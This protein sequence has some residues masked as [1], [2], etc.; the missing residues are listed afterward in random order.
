MKTSQLL[1]ETNPT[2]PLSTI[3]WTKGNQTLTED[4]T[5]TSRT[6]DNAVVAVSMATFTASCDDHL[7]QI[8]CSGFYKSTRIASKS[9][10]LF[11]HCI[12]KEDISGLTFSVGVGV[13]VGMAICL[14]PLLVAATVCIVWWKR[15]HTTTEKP[16]A[17]ESTENTAPA[18]CVL[19]ESMDESTRERKETTY[20]EFDMQVYE[21]PVEPNS[22]PQDDA[23]YEDV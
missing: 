12:D 19:Y 23:V 17:P 6:N 4:V 9:Q 14:V 15:R 5:S 8:Q 18:Q 1:C 20:E 10:T 3:I 21:T 16:K 2:R 11:V 7:S 22:S 13:G